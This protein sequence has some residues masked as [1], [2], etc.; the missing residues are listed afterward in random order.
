[1]SLVDAAKQPPQPSIP[2]WAS[3]LPDD[4]AAELRE[5]EALQDAGERINATAVWRALTSRGFEMTVGAVQHHFRR[6]CKCR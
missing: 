4:L 1:M 6:D 2:C 5:V 3:Q